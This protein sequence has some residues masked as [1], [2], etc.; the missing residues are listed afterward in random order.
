MK[1]VLI[2]LIVICAVLALFY[3]VGLKFVRMLIL[4]Q[5]NFPTPETG[6][7]SCSSSSC[8]C[9]I[10]SSASCRLRRYA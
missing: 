8:S 3:A 6:E 2:V 9:V 5:D 7:S 1:A 10:F 4:R